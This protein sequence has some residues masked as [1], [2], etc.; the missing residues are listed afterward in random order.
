MQKKEFPYNLEP[1]LLERE[2]RLPKVGSN[3]K[4]FEI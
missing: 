2:L 1:L 3:L 4:L